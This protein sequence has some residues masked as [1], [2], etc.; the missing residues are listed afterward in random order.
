MS[1]RNT[2]I[3]PYIYN[4]DLKPKI[5]VVLGKYCD[6]V[7]WTERGSGTGYYHG[8]IRDLDGQQTKR[9]WVEPL[10][11]ELKEVGVKNLLIA[12]EWDN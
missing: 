6:F 3:T 2:F 7:E 9:E 5:E 10:R 4:L 11:K 1:F 12:Y 8:V